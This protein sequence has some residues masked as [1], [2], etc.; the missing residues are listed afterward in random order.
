MKPAS[1]LAAAVLCGL[2]GAAIAQDAPGVLPRSATV[3]SPCPEQNFPNRVLFGDAH[4]HTAFS[5]DAGLIGA[6]LIPDDAYR[7]APRRGRQ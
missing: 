5:P 4:L 3:H 2:T 6:R 1:L 7:F